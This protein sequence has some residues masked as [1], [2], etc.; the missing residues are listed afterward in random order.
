M[1]VATT[2][3][4]FSSAVLTGPL[5]PK[6]GFP[7]EYN[8][9]NID[10]RNIDFSKL[11]PQQLPRIMHHGLP[12]TC[13]CVRRTRTLE[14]VL[15][16]RTPSGQG[17][18]RSKLS[19]PQSEQFTWAPL[20][21]VTPVRQYLG[22]RVSVTVGVV[23]GAALVQ[24]KACGGHVAKGEIAVSAS[25]T[26]APKFIWPVRGD[27]DVST[28]SNLS[29]GIDIAAPQGT[30]VKA[31]ADGIVTYAGN[32]LKDYGNLMLIQHGDGWVTAYALN[33]ELLVKRGD[34][35]RQGQ[36]IAHMDSLLH[37]EIRRGTQ[38]IDPLEA[39]AES[40]P[41]LPMKMH[42]WN[43]GE[44]SRLYAWIDNMPPGPASIHA[45][46]K[47]T[48]RMPCYEALAQF[49]GV[50]KNNSAIYLV[51]VTLRGQQVS[52][53]QVVAGIPFSYG[54]VNYPDKVREMTI[55]SDHDSKTIP[56]EITH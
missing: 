4:V 2:L 44:L 40:A 22:L 11:N 37:F 35:V 32:E 34:R 38:P 6:I 29:D 36:P 27:L 48:A 45:T 52:C 28:C 8:V 19:G 31:A 50:D 56:I 20:L 41:R 33:R 43:D 10:L 55:F 3:P 51:K 53:A 16:Q 49:A 21:E 5:V 54:R 42:G 13:D 18:L 39:I 25:N 7:S 24:A 17:P 30:I 23:L 47:I 1:V 14:P 12:E 9:Q 26:V 46:G 15:L